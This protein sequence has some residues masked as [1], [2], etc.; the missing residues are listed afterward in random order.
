[1]S[2]KVVFTKELGKNNY[3]NFRY[4]VNLKDIK[5]TYESKQI[6]TKL[7]VKNNSN[8]FGQNGFCT[9]ARAKSNPLGE[10]YI[11]DFRYYFN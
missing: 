6:V 1:V 3:A 7:I 4:G 11:Y 9:I 2:K 10:N 5:R 8:E